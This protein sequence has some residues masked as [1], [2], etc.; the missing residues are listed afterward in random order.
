MFQR[1]TSKDDFGNVLYYDR[2]AKARI[3]EINGEKVVVM[4]EL[5]QHAKTTF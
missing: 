1:K 4:D 2:K 5:L 3:Y